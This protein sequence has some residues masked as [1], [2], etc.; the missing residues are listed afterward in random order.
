[1]L[2]SCAIITCVST[3][4]KNTQPNILCAM[5]LLAVTQ[6]YVGMY[7]DNALESADLQED[8]LQKQIER[9]NNA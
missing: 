3:E 5:V 8:Q 9:S 1:M 6:S 4:N 7:P 2:Q